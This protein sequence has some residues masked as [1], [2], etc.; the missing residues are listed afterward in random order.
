MRETAPATPHIVTLIIDS[1]MIRPD[2]F[3]VPRAR[4]RNTIGVSTTSRPPA[5]NRLT[6]SVR[7]AYP[8]AWVVS[9]SIALS[10]EAR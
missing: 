6:S 7:N 3:D 8:S 4:L 1:A 10:A 9:G 5:L 2:I